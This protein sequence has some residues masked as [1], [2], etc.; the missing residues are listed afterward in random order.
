MCTTL[1]APMPERHPRQPEPVPETHSLSLSLL[2][3]AE[4]ARRNR[5]SIDGVLVALGALAVGLAAVVAESGSEQDED[6]G[7]AL[8]TVLGWA[9]AVWRVALVGALALA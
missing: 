8:A 5:R 9:P 3:P 2:A 1:G 4:P 7:Q 6:V